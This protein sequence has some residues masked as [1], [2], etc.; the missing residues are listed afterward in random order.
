[1]PNSNYERGVRFERERKAAWEEQ[2][3][4]C[5]RTAG[6]HGFA[7]LICVHPDK[8][9]VFVQC[10]VLSDGA[11]KQA[12]MLI[13]KFKQDPPIATSRYYRL[14]MEVKSMADR[15]LTTGTV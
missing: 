15:K 11:E 7:D 13:R 12:Y 3:Y 14:C 2:G 6:S 8:P 9:T 10:K 1:M 5:L 4:V